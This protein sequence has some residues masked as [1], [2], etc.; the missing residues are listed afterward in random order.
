M[1]DIKFDESN[2]KMAAALLRV[3]PKEVRGAASAAINRTLTRIKSRSSV[4]VR[5][6]YLAKAAGIK[7]SF[8]TRKA[9]SGNLAGAAVSKGA[10]MP[11]AS[12]RMVNARRGPVKAKVLK[13]GGMKPV[14]GAFFKSFPKGYEGPMM[15]TEKS[16]YPMKT[17]YG[18]SVPS[19]IG[20]NQVV[21]QIGEDA[22]NFYNKR[23]AHEVDHRMAKLLGG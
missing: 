8:S 2:V 1:I 15:R 6:R 21:E 18:P 19:M 10:P 4:R 11:L 22:E 3:A 14:K 20:N 12:F 9:S 13:A 5:E 17:P 7:S 16:R 23:F